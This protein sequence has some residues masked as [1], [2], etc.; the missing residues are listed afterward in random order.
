MSS[1]LALP[2]SRSHSSR[3]IAAEGSSLGSA[4]AMALRGVAVVGDGPAGLHKVHGLVHDVWRAAL[5]AD[6]HRQVSHALLA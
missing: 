4:L 1:Q 2:T 3:F 6:V 5:L